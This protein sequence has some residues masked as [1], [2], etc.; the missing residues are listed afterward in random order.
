MARK[1]LEVLDLGAS[2][3]DRKDF[4]SSHGGLI[5]N[6]KPREGE[7]LK[8]VDFLILENETAVLLG[9]NGAGKS[10]I[11]G[12]IMGDPRFK[13]SGK[14]KF[15][16]KNDLLELSPDKRAKL[17][18]FLSFQNP[19]DIPGISTTEMLREALMSKLERR[20]MLDE[21]REK[22][23]E[24]RK[25]L[26]KDNWFLER[27][28]NVGFSGGEK[29]INEILQM[30]A[31]EPKL[32]ILDEIDSGLDIDAAENI[33]E[34]LADYQRKSGC[35][36]LI[37]T[38]NMRILR[39]LKVDKT[40]LLRDGRVYKTGDAGLLKQVEENGFKAVFDGNSEEA[41]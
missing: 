17:G 16:E 34:I 31:L 7:I 2:V 13:A 18:I 26:G 5:K 33:S 11:A 29:K 36:Y 40:I 10:T 14:I 20:V 1:I 30:V 37:I 3:S 39:K 32:V 4:G 6:D 8:G 35:S 21:T 15:L 22:A 9:P 25:K 28:L 41:E 19:I 12:A 27:E 38:H 24:T 23:N